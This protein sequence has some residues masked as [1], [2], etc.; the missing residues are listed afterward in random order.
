MTILR[1]LSAA[2][3]LAAATM[4]GGAQ[5]LPVLGQGNVSCG[6]WLDRRTAA[7]AEADTMIAWVLGYITA[8]NEYAADPQADV[9]GGEGT[10]ALTARIDDF[11]RE[12]AAANLYQA[13]AAL[14]EQLRQQP[15][16]L[17]VP[18]RR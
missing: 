11:C 14:V 4:P 3:M 10:E 15:A 2:A 16:P 6:S 9:T 7:T 12:N 8:F 18:E 5:E 13:A 1:A 17:V